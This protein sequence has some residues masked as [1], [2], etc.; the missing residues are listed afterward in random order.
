MPNRYL[1]TDYSPA[2]IAALP[3][4]PLLWWLTWQ[5]MGHEV[6]TS[7]E[8]ITPRASV[9]ETDLYWWATRDVPETPNADDEDRPSPEAILDAL[10]EWPSINVFR[11]DRGEWTCELSGL[12]PHG[13]S[14]TGLTPYLAACRALL[15]F[16]RGLG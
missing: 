14:T 12:P 1:L 5:A 13:Y 6:S 15:A 4:E 9:S 11:E 7:H 8:S 10:A 3:D 16:K 2:E